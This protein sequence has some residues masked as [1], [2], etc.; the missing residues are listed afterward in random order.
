MKTLP[1]SD[2]THADAVRLQE[3]HNLSADS[4][5]GLALAGFELFAEAITGIPTESAVVVTHADYSAALDLLRQHRYQWHEL[6]F[7]AGRASGQR[8]AVEAGLADAHAVPDEP[9]GGDGA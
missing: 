8:R 9:E 2:E 6:R 1:V 7:A 5:V 3:L 4:L